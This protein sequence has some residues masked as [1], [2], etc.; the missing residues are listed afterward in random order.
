M[1]TRKLPLNAAE[2]LLEVVMRRYE[3]ASTLL[4]S[5]R[6]SEFCEKRAC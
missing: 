5:N 3:C 1:G 6:P 2:E 4:T